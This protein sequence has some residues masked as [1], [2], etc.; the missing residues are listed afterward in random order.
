MRSNLDA[1]GSKLGIQRVGGSNPLAPTI[2]FL[3]YLQCWRAH[4]QHL[5]EGAA[6]FPTRNVL[7]PLLGRIRRVDHVDHRE[8]SDLLLDAGPARRCSRCWRWRHTSAGRWLPPGGVCDVGPQSAL[9]QC[10]TIPRVEPRMRR[11]L[12]GGHMSGSRWRWVGARSELVSLTRLRTVPRL[13]L[14]VYG[15][16]SEK[17]KGRR[18]SAD[19]ETNHC[20]PCSAESFGARAIPLHALGS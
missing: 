19:A 10:R 2:Q 17:A 14:S 18:T 8:S 15:E 4:A 16:G 7:A 6:R 12:L 1:P 11:C 13:C 3:M 20:R 9:R 5:T